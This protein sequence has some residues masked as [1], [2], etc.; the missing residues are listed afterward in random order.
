MSGIAAL[1]LSVLGVACGATSPAPAVTPPNASAASG[2]EPAQPAQPATS[3]APDVQWHMRASFWQTLRAR[4]ALIDGDLAEAQRQADRLAKTD[5]ASMLPVAWKHWVAQLQ[6]DAA[7]LSL[8]ANLDE[9]ALALGRMA[10]A[11]GECHELHDAGPDKP[12]VQPQPWEDPPDTYDE[13]MQRHH[14][15]LT[16]MWDGLVLPS[17]KA[18]RSGTVTITRAPLRA[19][20]RAGE[21]IDDNARARIEEVRELAK[22]S[23]RADTYQERGRIYGELVARC[24]RCHYTERSARHV[25]P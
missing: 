14:L 2:S 1:V 8:A 6:Q 20:E 13:R 10:L 3:S 12:R 21:P 17:E 7:A 4:D 5:Y 23:R 19:P 18:W 16:Q 25:M 22:Q 24:A 11:C 15:G 9:A